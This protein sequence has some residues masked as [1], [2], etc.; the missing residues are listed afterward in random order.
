MK[1]GEVCLNTNDV[2]TLANFY[3][4]LLEIENDSDDEVHQI[5]LCEETQL[6]IYNDSTSK[7]NNNQNISLAFTVENIEA[8][9]AKLLAMRVEIIEKPTKRPWGTTNMSFY[10]PDRNVIYFRSF[11]DWYISQ[12]VKQLD[13]LEFERKEKKC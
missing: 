4:K 6:S 3:K 12:Y 7:N 11:T 8:E 1:I 9:Y 2:I 10:D 5:L 13:E